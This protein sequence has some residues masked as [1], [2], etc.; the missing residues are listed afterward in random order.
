MKTTLSETKL[1]ENEIAPFAQEIVEQSIE[2]N[3]LFDQG[4]IPFAFRT[5]YVDS[6]NGIYGIGEMIKVIL[7]T[8][9]A[10]MPLG[11]ENTPLR[12][13]AIG[14]AVYADQVED[15][16][17][18]TFCAATERYTPGTIRQY[19]ASKKKMPNMGRIQLTND[20]DCER[21]S[22]RPRVKYYLPE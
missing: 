8:L 3:Q 13:I 16:V 22:P 21:P 6:E 17:R 10:K 12:A 14:N 11:A 2:L 18:A 7:D 1:D 5:H 19:L 15:M 4:E 20:E 9:G